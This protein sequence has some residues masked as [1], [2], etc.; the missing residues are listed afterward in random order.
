MEGKSDS[1]DMLLGARAVD[2]VAVAV[3]E[4]VAA[5][6]EYE[7]AVIVAVEAVASLRCA[8]AE[9]DVS[10]YSLVVPNTRSLAKWEILD[11]CHN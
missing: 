5:H 2:M 3:A 11:F 10:T 1:V 4:P 6:T 8:A 9:A 7:V